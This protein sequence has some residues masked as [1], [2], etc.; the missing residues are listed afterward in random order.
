MSVN[1]WSCRGC[2]LQKVQTSSHEV[3]K[4]EPCFENLFK[5]CGGSVTYRE[6]D[7]HPN[8]PIDTCFYVES[9]NCCSNL[10]SKLICQCCPTISPRVTKIVKEAL[11]EDLDRSG[12][13]P[14]R[15]ALLYVESM[16]CCSNV[17]FDQTCFFF[18]CLSGELPTTE[19]KITPDVQP[20]RSIESKNSVIYI[21]SIDCCSNLCSNEIRFCCPCTTQSAAK[22]GR[23][24]LV[25]N[26]P[27]PMPSIKA[28]V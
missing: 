8:R 26:Q 3:E 12:Y 2:F 15:T 22:I 5:L 23:E 27:S 1:L 21:E 10:C 14:P 6:A 18:P 19:A 25:A 9:M 20:N 4:P 16:N 11:R 7:L 28:D 17:L 13:I 24:V